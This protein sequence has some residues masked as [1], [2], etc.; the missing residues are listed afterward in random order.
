MLPDPLHSYHLG[1]LGRDGVETEISVDSPVPSQRQSSVGRR[2]DLCIP[3]RWQASI[4]HCI[5]GGLLSNAPPA[6]LSLG[7]HTGQNT[8]NKKE[9]A[10][11]RNHD[12]DHKRCKEIG[13]NVA[14]FSIMVTFALLP[15]LSLLRKAA[16]HSWGDSWKPLGIYICMFPR[17]WHPSH[18]A[19]WGS[20][21]GQQIHKFDTTQMAM[22]SPPLFF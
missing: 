9:M 17:Q 13:K 8:K 14:F 12:E 21:F 15:M 1:C 7:C 16:R 19:E 2:V 3:S 5:D 22:L 6:S 4:T 11:D 10:R 20:Y 18:G